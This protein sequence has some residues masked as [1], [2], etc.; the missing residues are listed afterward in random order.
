MQD[1]QVH[2]YNDCLTRVYEIGVEK[3]QAGPTRKL[4]WTC[5]SGVRRLLVLGL[6]YFVSPYS[7][8]IAALPSEKGEGFREMKNSGILG[9]LA[10]CHFVNRLPER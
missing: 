6:G 2:A 7:A 4:V 5:E 3:P 9:G 1:D 8:R 10:S